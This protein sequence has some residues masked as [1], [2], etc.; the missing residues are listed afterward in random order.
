MI[1]TM[2]CATCKLLVYDKNI[3]RPGN[4]YTCKAFPG[5]IPEEIVDGW[6]H[7]NYPFPG[8]NGTMYQEGEPTII[9]VANAP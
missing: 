5:G 6:D 1:A 8:D 2:V 3:I 4:P 9:E 7:A